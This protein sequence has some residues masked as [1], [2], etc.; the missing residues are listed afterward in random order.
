MYQYLKLWFKIQQALVSNY[1][2]MQV[3][4]MGCTYKIWYI[5]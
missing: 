2:I 1:V 5:C 4:A 3:D